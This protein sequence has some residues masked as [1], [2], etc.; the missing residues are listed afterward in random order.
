MSIHGHP[1]RGTP[2]EMARWNLNMGF[3]QSGIEPEEQGRAGS[4]LQVAPDEA[5]AEMAGPTQG[6]S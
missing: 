2:E 5:I 3:K 1:E 6:T 4:W